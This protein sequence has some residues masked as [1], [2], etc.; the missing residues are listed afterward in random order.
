MGDPAGQAS[1]GLQP[2]QLAHLL[3]GLPERLLGSLAFDQLPD[4]AA[5]VIHN[6]VEVVI[7]GPRAP[8]EERE[9]SDHTGGAADGTSEGGS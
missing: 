8:T 2:L 4:A 3:L 6:G 7:T 9:Q 5:D 1:D